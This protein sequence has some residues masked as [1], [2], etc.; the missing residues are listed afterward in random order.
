M[1]NGDVRGEGG[2]NYHAVLE[3]LDGG[4]FYPGGGGM[5]LGEESGGIIDTTVF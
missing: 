4:I 2:D 3:M 5:D 1:G